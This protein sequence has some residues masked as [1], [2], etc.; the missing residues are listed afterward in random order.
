MSLPSST[1][2]LDRLTAALQSE[3]PRR[4]RFGLRHMLY[5]VFYCALAFWIIA[6]LKAPGVA[7][8]LAI[9][10]AAATGIAF[11]L[12]WRR[13]NQ[14][15]ML[16]GIVAVA[17]NSELPLSTTLEA[18]A[19]QFAFGYPMKVHLLSQ[20][21]N[22]GMPLPEALDRVPGLLP[23]DAGLL[24][25]VGHTA[26]ALPGAVREAASIRST[27][28]SEW[29]GIIL[30]IDY[31]LFASVAI[32]SIGAYL[33]LYQMPRMR[34]ILNDFAIKLPPLT[35]AMFR[36]SDFV[37]RHEAAVYVLLPAE[38]VLAFCVLS[39][40]YGW[41]RLNVPLVDRLF[42]R[43]HSALVLRS[44]AWFVDGGVPLPRA[45]ALLT[46]WYPTEWVRVRLSRVVLDVRH[47]TDWIESLAHHGIV[48]RADAAVLDSARRAGNL[49]WALRE[50]AA[51]S[52]R[53]LA[54]RLHAAASVLLPII[55][56]ALGATVALI[57][58]A[59]L[60]PLSLLIERLAP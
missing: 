47:G 32:Q 39:T 56:L 14:Q 3:L 13:S 41:S 21:L 30:R 10:M 54:Y 53:R 43:R 23:A 51:G 19:S 58:A 22:G 60:H 36:M 17:L 29:T 59:Y 49:P 28:K 34:A 35:A 40:L 24:A 45:I 1:D 2:E 31:F 50:S 33:L 11:V 55:V 57:G 9:L 12:A 5:L 44:I 27:V 26:G 4:W 52:E 15:Q 37:E 6:A 46:S 18:F 20:L 38:V 8:L 16:L 25:R 7:A 48:G 42:A